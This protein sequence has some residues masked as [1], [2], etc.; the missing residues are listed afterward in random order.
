MRIELT[1]ETLVERLSIVGK[2][3]FNELILSLKFNKFIINKMEA[4]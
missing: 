2:Y 3:A 4:K 1:Y